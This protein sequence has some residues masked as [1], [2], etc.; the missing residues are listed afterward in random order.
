MIHFASPYLVSVD[1]IISAV[2]FAT[3]IVAFLSFIT[4]VLAFLLALLFARR[5]FGKRLF[6]DM[7]LY[8]LLVVFFVSTATHIKPKKLPDYYGSTFSFNKATFKVFSHL[9]KKSPDENILVG[10]DSIARLFGALVAATDDHSAKILAQDFFGFNDTSKL[11]SELGKLSESLQ[12]R[13]SLSQSLT[14]YRSPLS[15][16]DIKY[17]KIFEDVLCGKSVL[18]KNLETQ[19][20][21]FSTS[22]FAAYWK[23]CFDETQ[24]GDFHTS[25]KQTVRTDFM[26]K[27]LKSAT[28]V[29]DESGCFRALRLSFADQSTSMIFLMENLKDEKKQIISDSFGVSD[30]EKILQKFRTKTADDILVK[31][32][33]FKML[34]K[35]IDLNNI[36]KES[37][38]DTD[39][40][41]SKILT[42]NKKIPF[43]VKSES[44]VVVNERGAMY[45]SISF[46]KALSATFPFVADRPF[47]F[48]I[49]DERAEHILLMGKLSD[50]SKN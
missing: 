39:N 19:V 2:A 37:G 15:D 42:G 21:I 31:I 10:S 4:W 7:F 13:K 26:I 20:S 29:I 45:R 8:A 25:K 1:S 14:L 43:T 44:S 34:R 49:V 6:L 32:P 9:E 18:S 11:L 28:S 24:S 5:G 48:F 35:Y 40:A 27:K 50:P 33:K 23:D 30:F 12:S 41:F 46:A 38:I 36:L 47:L 3:F 22:E 17:S 16:I